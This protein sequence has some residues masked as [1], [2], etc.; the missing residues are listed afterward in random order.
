MAFC[1]LLRGCPACV[2]YSDF[3]S[4]AHETWA[5]QFR[6]TKNYGS[7]VIRP[8]AGP[9]GSRCACGAAGRGIWMWFQ[10]LVFGTTSGF[11]GGGGRRPSLTPPRASVAMTLRLSV[12]PCLC[13]LSR[14]PGVR[15]PRVRCL[16]VRCLGD[17]APS[18]FRRCDGSILR[19]PLRCS[20]RSLR[21][22]R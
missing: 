12:P 17:F 6:Q 16:R 15:C 9:R 21:S 19:C 22:L 18:W 5:L 7:V 10:E 14:G 1:L 11:H 20:L 8:L 3:D 2:D 13:G 4:D